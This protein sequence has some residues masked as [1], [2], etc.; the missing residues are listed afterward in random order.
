MSVDKLRQ[1]IPGPGEYNIFQKGA[2]ERVPGG[3]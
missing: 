1:E 2:W 3:M